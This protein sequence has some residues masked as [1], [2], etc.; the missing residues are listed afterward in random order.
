[1]L[2]CS[3]F[4]ISQVTEILQGTPGLGFVTMYFPLPSEVK[5]P[6][7]QLTCVCAFAT[8]GTETETGFSNP[9]YNTFILSALTVSAGRATMYSDLNGYCIN[10]PF[11]VSI[12]ITP[13]YSKIPSL[14]ASAKYCP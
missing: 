3:P 4:G 2:L 12:L 11:G 1:M 10:F 9:A 6:L 13:S 14:F 7:L 5:T 8:P